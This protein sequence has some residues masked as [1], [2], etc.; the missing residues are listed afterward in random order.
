VDWMHLR[1]FVNTSVN[2]GSIRSFTK[3]TPL[4]ADG[5]SVSQLL[6]LHNLFRLRLKVQNVQYVIVILKAAIAFRILS[7][8]RQSQPF[9]DLSTP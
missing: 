1:T 9:V 8:R 6:M 2:L 7:G 4:R 3:R 5:Q